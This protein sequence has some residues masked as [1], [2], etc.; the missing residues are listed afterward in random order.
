MHFLQKECEKFINLVFVERAHKLFESVKVHRRAKLL[1]S[2]LFISL[3]L[4]G[5]VFLDRVL[6]RC[7]CRKGPSTCAL[8]S[9]IFNLV[10]VEEHHAIMVHSFPLQRKLTG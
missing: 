3:L 2:A 10:L 8:V 9:T 6:A 4:A 5:H 1:D 7:H